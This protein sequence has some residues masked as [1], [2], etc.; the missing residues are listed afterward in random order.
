MMDL[1]GTKM[2]DVLIWVDEEDHEI[3]YGEKMDTHRREQLHRAFS[4]FLYHREA[5]KLLI[6]RRAQGKYHSGDL[7]TNACCSHPRKGESLAQAVVR[8]AQ[9]ELGIALGPHPH[10]IAAGKFQYYQ[11]YK[12][13]AEHEVDHVFLLCATEFPTLHVNPDE[14]ADTM[15][16]SIPDLQHWMEVHPE[17]FTA[18]F[19]KALEL[20]LL[21]IHRMEDISVDMLSC[22]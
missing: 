6:H 14:I 2:E 18:W 5:Q 21:Q 15:W 12:N 17:Q 20:T 3:G 16:I 22:L 9:E 13:C 8:R 19:P 7:W 10:I 11:K 4:L 1:G